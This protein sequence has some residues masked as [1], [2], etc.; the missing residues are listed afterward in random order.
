MYT[1]IMNKYDI[2][3]Y[4]YIYIYTHIYIYIERERYYNISCAGLCTMPGRL[5]GSWP[6]GASGRA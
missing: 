3:K 2:Y 6:A 1:Y 4:I 5:Q